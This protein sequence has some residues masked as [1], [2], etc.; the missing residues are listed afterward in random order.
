MECCSEFFCFAVDLPQK[1]FTKR[2]ILSTFGSIFD[3]LGFVAPVTLITRLLFQ[4]LSR[5]KFDWVEPLL[6]NDSAFWQRWLNNVSR[7]SSAMIHRPLIQPTFQ[8]DALVERELRHFCDASSQGYSLAS[9][10]RIAS[11]EGI[12][13]CNFL[14]GKSRLAP[15]KSTSIS[16]LELV[17]ATMSNHMDKMLRLELEGAVTT[18]VFWSV[19]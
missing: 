19:P 3:P 4:D 18:S 8:Y 10:L 12:I 11:A 17:A 14:F 5:R 1:P 15:L 13:S 2:G 16:K 6:E 7:L 9:Y